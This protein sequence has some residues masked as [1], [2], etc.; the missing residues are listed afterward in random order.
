MESNTVKIVK[1]LGESNKGWTQAADNA[2]KQANKTIKNLTGIKVLEM[3]ANIEN[4][5]IVEYKTTLEVAF[6]VL[7]KKKQKL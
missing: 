4:G 2:V 6:P 1:I 5:E 7:D 3:S